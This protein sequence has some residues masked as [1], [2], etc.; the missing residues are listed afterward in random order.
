MLL[1]LSSSKMNETQMP[2]VQPLVSPTTD[3]ALCL[4]PSKTYETVSPLKM[5]SSTFIN[6]VGM[7]QEFC[8][9]QGFRNVTYEVVEESGPPHMRMFTM[10]A[11]VQSC[12]LGKRGTAHCKQL[13]KH[14]AARL[15]LQHLQSLSG[16]TQT[17]DQNLDK[18]NG[19]IQEMFENGSQLTLEQLDIKLAKCEPA[20][21]ISEQTKRMETLFITHTKTRRNATQDC[22]VKNCHTTFERT[23][24]SKIPDTMKARMRMTCDKYAELLKCN[25]IDLIQ[26]TIRDIEDTLQIKLQQVSVNS[27]GNNYTVCLRL[28]SRPTITQFGLGETRDKAKAHAMYNIILTI[29]TF[30]N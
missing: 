23:Y 20:R 17:N 10:E 27:L 13:A 6:Y 11:K 7:L 18:N 8:V 19:S 14:E 2:S 26:E 16:S 3:D 25:R 30:L 29:V 5:P 28:T 21:S 9:Q 4:T 15:L 1:L 24:S 22:L 12:M